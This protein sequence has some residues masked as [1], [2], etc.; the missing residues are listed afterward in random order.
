[1]E[2]AL[3]NNWK[4]I[5]PFAFIFLILGGILGGVIV[6]F[7]LKLG[8]A[9]EKIAIMTPGKILVGEFSPLSKTDASPKIIS[10]SKEDKIEGF[11]PATDK[12][13]ALSVQTSC[14]GGAL[15]VGDIGPLSSPTHQR[16]AYI[17]QGD[18][19]IWISD[20]D[21]NQKIKISTQGV[22]ESELFWETNLSLAGWSKNEKYLIYHVGIGNEG[23]GINPEDKF[24][25]PI[26]AGFYA[27]D[28]E[29]GKIYFLVN[30]PN[31]VDFLPQSNLIVFIKEQRKEGQQNKTDLYTYDL[32]TGSIE[33]L[34]KES[35]GG[36][37]VGQFSF[38]SNKKHFAY[39]NAETEPS[40]SIL[41]YA[42]LDNIDK[43]ELV[44]G[45]FAEIQFPKI[46][47][48][49]KFVAYEKY[50][51]ATCP[52]GGGC[53]QANLVLYN[54]ETNQEKSLAPIKKILYWFDNNRIVAVGGSYSGPWNLQLVDTVS[55]TAKTIAT[56]EKLRN[57]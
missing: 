42:S 28:L 50:T 6:L 38:S 40:S 23:M 18:Q 5:V 39:V 12:S 7:G 30:L 25:P 10:M 51:P 43:Q 37:F 34:T 1:M 4:K 2:P 57:Q 17:D 20:S 53:P 33:R 49:G 52:G 21:G 13:S 56:N 16:I 22:P 45:Q 29:E 32:N 27:A 3:S 14:C 9:P 15:Y 19:N 41:I 47:P 24:A 8:E 48:D 44:K 35:I 26:P 46:S 36:T 55:G 31:F 11:D 54:L